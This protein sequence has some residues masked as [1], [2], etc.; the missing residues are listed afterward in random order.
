MM[1]SDTS[2]ATL[3]LG[4]D[5][6]VSGHG[7]LLRFMRCA[8]FATAAS[9]CVGLCCIISNEWSSVPEMQ[10]D[11]ATATSSASILVQIK[12]IDPGLMTLSAVQRLAYFTTLLG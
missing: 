3:G 8:F 9:C 6:V 11:S 4:L 5:V 2:N 1:V 10:L 12:A 7:A